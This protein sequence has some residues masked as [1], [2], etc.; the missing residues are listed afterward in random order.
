MKRLAALCLAVIPVFLSAGT[1]FAA[2]NLNKGLNDLTEQIVSELSDGQKK[3]IAVLDFSYTDG[4]ITELG[5]YISEELITRLYKTKRFNIIDSQHLEKAL[6]EQNLRTAEDVDEKVVQ[7]FGRALGVDAVCTGAITDLAD[8]IKIN[9]RLVSVKTGTVFAVASTEIVVDDQTLAL[10]VNANKEEE[11]MK[12]KPS[13]KTGNLM[14]NGGFTHR[15]DGWERS[16]GNVTKG[17]SKVEIISFP[18]GKSGKAL[19]IRHE[20]EGHLQFAQIIEVPTPDLVFSA[21][22]QASS[23][24]GMIIGF[25]GTGVVQI[26]LQ[27]MDEEGSVIG[28]TTLLNYVKNPFADTPLIGVPRQKSDTY[29]THSIAINEGRFYQNYKVDIRREIE[30]NLLGVDINSLRKVAVAVW[31]GANNQQAGSE[32]WITDVS[33][34]SK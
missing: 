24:E 20:G 32:I 11:P 10:I 14:K 21:S 5:K 28:Q 6:E 29:M 12:A 16:I 2:Q 25:S 30:D 23:H 34:M 18:N 9:A 4:K 15:Y 31:C 33:L 3:K 27:Y 1:V 7:Q 13:R 22:F 26:A 8:T 17:S 19:H